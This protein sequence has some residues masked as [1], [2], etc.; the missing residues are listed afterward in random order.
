[1]KIEVGKL[2]K[3]GGECNESG[4]VIKIVNK[5]PF[6]GT[7]RFLYETISGKMPMADSVKFFCKNSIFAKNLTLFSMEEEVVILRNGT[8][9]TATHYVDGEKCGTGIAKCSPEDEFDFAFGAKLALERLFGEVESTFDWI[10]F[11]NG[12]VS[13]QV[14]RENIYDFLEN[15]EKHGFEWESGKRATKHNPFAAYDNLD[16]FAKTFIR[17][18]KCEP[19]ENIWISIHEGN[20]AFETDFPESEV[21]VW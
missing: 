15:C 16:G 7:T 8:T 5:F 6:C 1:M 12:E 18:P 4:S 19:K 2:Y 3:V 21:F 10:R 20:L 14:N 13:V 9:V 17:L 11:T